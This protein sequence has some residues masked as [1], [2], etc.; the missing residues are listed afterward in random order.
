LKQ[1]TWVLLVIV[2]AAVSAPSRA[3]GDPR[4]HTLKGLCGVEVVVEDLESTTESAGLHREDLITDAELRLRTAGVKVLSLKESSDAPGCP[5]LHVNV[6]AFPQGSGFVYAV[7]VELFQD[8]LLD[9]GESTKLRQALGKTPCALDQDEISAFSL[10][11]WSGTHVLT[12]RTGYVGYGPLEAVHQA[13]R[14]R[15]DKFA[16][17]FRAENPKK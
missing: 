14:D 8:A 5:W 7:N 13:V 4:S 17:D 1:L 11:S 16:N 2:L 15:V 6:N 3:A 10:W 12:W 9:R